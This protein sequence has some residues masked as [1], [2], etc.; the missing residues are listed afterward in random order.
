[1]LTV[2][3]KSRQLFVLNLPQGIDYEGHPAGEPT[4]GSYTLAT[5]T[6]DGEVGTSLVQKKLPGSLTWLAGEVKGKLPV[7]LGLIPEFKA[8]C[9]AG[10]LVVQS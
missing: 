1:M 10:I 3:N 5:T 2:K 7:G 6:P 9:D 8:A 4:E